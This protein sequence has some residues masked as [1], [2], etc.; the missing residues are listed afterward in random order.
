[1]S[2]LVCR[3]R[4]TCTIKGLPIKKNDFFQVGESLKN[5]S[6]HLTF[7]QSKPKFKAHLNARMGVWNRSQPEERM[8]TM[9]PHTHEKVHTLYLLG[10]VACLCTCFNKQNIHLFR[11]LLSLL[12]GYLSAMSHN[13][14]TQGTHAHISPQ[15]TTQK[16]K[17]KE[18]TQCE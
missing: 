2:V 10:I 18:N 9:S 8:S 3:P 7:N 17:G 4:P 14:H 11:S 5:K 15:T 13:T 12:C 16:H 1:M 6:T